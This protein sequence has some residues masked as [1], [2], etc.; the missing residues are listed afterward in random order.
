MKQVEKIYRPVPFW[1]WNSELNKDEL[2]KQ[3]EWM[4]ENGIGGFFMHA[5][6]GLTTEYLGKEWFE[7]ID[8]CSK[9]AL[10]LGMSS[11]IALNRSYL[12]SDYN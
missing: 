3:V 2:V 5:R 10:E 7:C 4:N 6:G 1:S 12:D 9:R 11:P 8:A